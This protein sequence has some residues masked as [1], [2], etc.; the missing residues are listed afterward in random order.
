MQAELVNHTEFARGIGYITIKVPCLKCDFYFKNT[1][2]KGE[3]KFREK[4]SFS[5]RKMMQFVENI[6]FL[7]FYINP[8]NPKQ[9]FVVKP[10][11]RIQY[12]II[13]ILIIGLDFW[14][15][16]VYS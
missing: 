15:R 14:V 13:A 8:N 6:K 3:L 7:T 9:F 4:Y 10:E 1:R 5:D 2:I 12:A 16:S 11:Q